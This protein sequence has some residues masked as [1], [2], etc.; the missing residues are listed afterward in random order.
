MSAIDSQGRVVAR[1]DV[2]LKTKGCSLVRS[3]IFCCFGLRG[4]GVDYRFLVFGFMILLSTCC[5]P[6]RPQV[7]LNSDGR[8]KLG[9]L[10]QASMV[11]PADDKSSDSPNDGADPA[12]DVEG[13]IDME[14]E[15]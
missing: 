8:L 11:L 9:C 7:Y 12:D 6:R 10:A 14:V 13:D 15:V 1:K 5:F 2:V 4:C 3:L